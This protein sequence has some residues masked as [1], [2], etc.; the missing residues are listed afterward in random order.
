MEQSP[1][2]TK[3]SSKSFGEL[4]E[5]L[6]KTALGYGFGL[7]HKHDFQAKYKSQGKEF[8]PYMILEICNPAESYEV[9]KINPMMGHMMPKSIIAYQDTDGQCKLSLM[10][11]DPERVAKMFPDV[12]GIKG[13]ALK[14]QQVLHAII[15]RAV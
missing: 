2:Y 12:P 5:S 13:T 7:M 11:A 9:L 1:F 6:E 15:D 3:T 14:V 8:A 4:L 10:K